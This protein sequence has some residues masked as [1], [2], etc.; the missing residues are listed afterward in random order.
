MPVYEFFCPHCNTVFS[1]FSKRV[2]TRKTPACPRCQGARME[3]QV[4]RFA[5]TGRAADGVNGED[6]GDDLPIDERRMEGAM[7]T[8]AREAESMNE[9]DPRQAARLMRRL[10]DMTGMRF[11]ASMEQAVQRMEAGE[12]PDKIEQ[13]MGDLMETEEEPF[14]LPGAATG[15]NA[16]G[17]RRAPARDDKLYDL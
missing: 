4:S 8:L 10:S 5:A 11:G 2:N 9:E 1:F 7:E 16:A 13:E 12:D 14:I 3:R 15:G 6:G 17:P